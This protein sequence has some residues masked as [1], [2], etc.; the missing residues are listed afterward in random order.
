M[1]QD[2]EEGQ[3]VVNAEQKLMF[4]KIQEASCTAEVVLAPLKGLCS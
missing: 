2:G 3:S 1:A 4:H